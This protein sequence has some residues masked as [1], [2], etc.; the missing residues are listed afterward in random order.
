MLVEI[1]HQ[2]AKQNHN[3]NTGS[4]SFENLEKFRYLGK[5]VTKQNVIHEEIK[6]RLNSGNACYHSV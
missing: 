3:V 5:T 4:T 2:N 6:G 1:C